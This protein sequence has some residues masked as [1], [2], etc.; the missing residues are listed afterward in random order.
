MPADGRRRS[1][2]VGVGVLLVQS[3]G[4]A[5]PGPVQHHCERG[6]RTLQDRCG[7]FVAQLVPPGQDQDLT[8]T[9]GQLAQ[10][11][12]NGDPFHDW[13]GGSPPPSEAKLRSLVSSSAKAFCWE[14]F[15]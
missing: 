9:F 7:I 4:E 14:S 5:D 11:L 13:T 2:V 8:I 15:R 3:S 12:Q 6:S 1:S 10:R